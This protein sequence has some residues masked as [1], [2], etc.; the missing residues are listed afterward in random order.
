MTL[1]DANTGVAKPPL[2]HPVFVKSLSFSGDGK[3]L[4]T[5]DGKST[6]R[7]WEVQSQREITNFATSSGI[8]GPMPF[9]NSISENA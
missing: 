2:P 8:L 7:V 9:R 5:M 1:W 6:I 4:A 3:L